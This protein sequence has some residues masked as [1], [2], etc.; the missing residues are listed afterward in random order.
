MDEMFEQDQYSSDSDDEQQLQKGQVAEKVDGLLQ[1]Q[2]GLPLTQTKLG[3][4]FEATR[5]IDSIKSTQIYQQLK[6][7][8]AKNPAWSSEEN[9]EIDFQKFLSSRIFRFK[10]KQ[11]QDQIDWKLLTFFA[12][13]TC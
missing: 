8:L 5:E 4:F 2:L 9:T 3:D 11:D 13:Y 1:F 10:D 7:F 6:K 12:L